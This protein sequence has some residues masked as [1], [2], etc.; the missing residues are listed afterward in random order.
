MQ[1]ITIT[2]KKQLNDF[3][4]Q[5]TMSQFLQSWQW[6]E[7]QGRA[8]GK[9]IRLGVLENNELVAAATLVKKILPMGKNY[10]LCP[11]GPIV[12]AKRDKLKILNE[13]FS[14]IKELAEDE[15]VI[16]LRF[17]PI[18]TNDNSSFII[19]QTLDIQP[20]KTLILDLTKSEEELLKEMHQKTRY[21][22]KLSEKKKVK[23]VEAGL[24]RFDD[25]WQLMNQTGERDNFRPHGIDY[26]RKMLE[27]EN[28]FIKLYF[29]EYNGK[30]VTTGI[31]SYFGDTVT[32]LHGASADHD[33]EV[34]APY[35]LHWQIIKE[36]KQAGYKYYDLFGIDEKRW[37]GVT[38]FKK[39]FGGFEHNYPGTF[40]LAFDENWYSIYKMIRKARRTF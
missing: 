30:P 8:A 14:T 3:V 19:Q 31:F 39:G 18:S 2:D 1:I 21:N 36:A 4:D 24:E 23:V 6:G 38:R 7:F 32:Y 13:L 29:A 10:F 12:G 9:I 17:E 26:Y 20:S 28:D 40:D 22:I 16:F 34:M 15:S 25:F 35:S 11:R 27:A 37:P 5:E 33:R